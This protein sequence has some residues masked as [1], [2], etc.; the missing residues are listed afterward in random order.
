MSRRRRPSWRLVSAILVVALLA[1]YGWALVG[2]GIALIR[3]GTPVGVV[4]GLAVLILPLLV[5]VLIARELRLAM[6]VQSMA[7]TAAEAGALPIDDLP[8]SPGGRIDRDAADAAFGEARIAVEAAPV[9]WRAWYRLAFAYDAAR[10]RRRAREA[11]RKAAGLYRADPSLRQASDL[12]EP[13][14][15][16]A[17]P[18]RPDADL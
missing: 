7:D 13:F 9:D 14:G 15:D 18:G 10:D 2:R 12:G 16:S 1:L 4:L 11:L 3:A 5:L 8:R 6:T 17:D